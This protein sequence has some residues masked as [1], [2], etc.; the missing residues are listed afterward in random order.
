MQWSFPRR[1]KRYILGAA[2]LVLALAAGVG[3]N[4]MT[5]TAK[6]CSTVDTVSVTHVVS[7]DFTVLDEMK[8]LGLD[9]QYCLNVER[10]IVASPPAAL[11]AAASGQSNI[12]FANGGSLMQ[13]VLQGIDVKLL[14]PAEIGRPDN[15]GIYVKAD[16][17]IKTPKDLNGK[18][19]GLISLNGT[20]QAAIIERLGRSGADLKSIKMIPYPFPSMADGIASGQIDAGQLAEPYLTAA[21]SNVRLLFPTW[22]VWAKSGH[23]AL[24]YWF[25]N[26][27]WAATH[28]DVVQR[29]EQALAK[30]TLAVQANPSVIAQLAQNQD[31]SQTPA[32]VAKQ[33]T[34]LLGV[35]PMMVSYATELKRMQKLGMITGT[36]PD[37]RK[38]FVLPAP[39]SGDDVL[40]GLDKGD[41]INGGDGNDK[42]LGYEGND[43]LNGGAGNDII[44]GGLGNDTISGGDGNDV[45]VATDGQKDSI[46][47]G[48]GKD[49]A[50]IDAGKDTTVNCEI[51]R[52]K[53]PKNIVAALGWG[54]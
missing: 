50:Y 29:F 9:Q 41:T 24:V 44:D 52:T 39:T 16:S 27:S 37:P 46:D 54:A 3:A 7:P 21:G 13:A 22:T 10:H 47:C 14:F 5:R 45:I 53:V 34:P 51:V 32:V 6:A 30:A 33:V 28:A 38:Y 42:I 19:I 4:A 1:R 15:N 35:D 12:S 43:T 25:A 36:P 23:V 2:T 17:P 40:W 48:A 8:A 20:G 18:T 31:P 49:T 26:G 11:Q